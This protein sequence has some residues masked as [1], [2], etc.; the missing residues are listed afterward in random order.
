MASAPGDGARVFAL[1]A[2][3]E[4]WDHRATRRRGI[5]NEP[6][7][8]AALLATLGLL[9]AVSILSSRASGRIGVPVVLIFLGIGILAGSEGIGRIPF[10]DYALAFRL[11]TVALVL[12]L[13][14]GGL[15]TPL[16]LVRPYLAPSA[17]LATAGVLG[18]AA[19][20]ALGARAIGLGWA[21][22][23]LLGAIVSSTDAAAVFSLLRGSGTT[24][25]RRPAFTLEI[26][27][28]MND[29][30]AVILTLACTRLILGGE[31][32]DWRLLL[33][34]P[35]EIALG[36]AGGAAVGFGGRVL[37]PRL[38]S[39]A[40]GIYAVLTVALAFLAFGVSTIVH[41][42]GFLAV[43][44]AAVILGNGNLPFRPSIL[45]VHDAL[46][47]LSQIIMFLML[48]LLV[49]P[50][51][52]ADVAMPGLVL[53]V[54]LAVVAR[55]LVVAAC[56]GP[57]R[58]PA[59]EIA[60]IGWA[61]LRGAVP[62]ILAT[63]PV[64]A[65]APG[66]T[67]IFDLV[68]FIVV[69]SA[70]LPGTTMRWVTRWLRVESREAPPP[71]ALL[72]IASAEPLSG[73]IVSFT[74]HPSLVVAGAPLNEVPLP[75]NAAVMLIVRDRSLIAPRGDT[76]LEPGD[77]VYLICEAGDLP[78]IQLMFGKMEEP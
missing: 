38:R 44:V 3:P 29:P 13:F 8:T 51:R 61:G 39:A 73:E 43:Y 22:S 10:E 35:I 33:D 78:F 1:V 46:A 5:L 71:P 76:V 27:S 24:V 45:R 69:V 19:L 70:L 63:Y 77:H 66:A 21:E 6:L 31:N 62:I 12:I 50:S 4:P 55:P 67:R 60:L 28:G 7:H 47:W 68:F 49:F 14:D 25:M 57:F 53:G 58:Y 32:P 48:G 74:V 52:L 56:L 64:L 36:A 2:V 65:G 11:G 40:G 17:T 18:T 16:A 26:E 34:I 72:E 75:Q 59:A 23:L 41:G 37:L 9:M 42:S 30:V 20:L 54:L 15:N